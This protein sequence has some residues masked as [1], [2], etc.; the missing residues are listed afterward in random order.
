[1]ALTAQQK[2]FTLAGM[3]LAMFLAALDQTV[4]ATAGPV[5]QRDLSIAP[6]LYTWITTAYLVASTV[7]VPVYGKLSDTYGRR[8]I[9]VIGIVIFLAGSVACGLSKTTAQLIVFRALQGVGSASI[10]TSAFAVVADLFT[11][12]ERGKYSGVFGAVF[13]VSSLV[14]PLLGGLITDTVG[15]HWV[16]FINLPL[17]ALALAFIALR[18]PPLKPPEDR[19]GTVDVVGALLLGL[20]AVPLLIALSLGRPEVREGEVGFAWLSWPELALFATA[21]VGVAAFVAW[22]LRAKSPLIDLRLFRLPMVSWGSLTVF[23]LGGAFLTPMVFLPLFM[24]N[25]VGV[26][27][28]ASGLTIS[29]LVLGVVAGN[30][31]SGQL[32]ARLGR[33]KPIMLASLALLSAA[34]LLMV[35]TLST[36]STQGGVTAKMVLLGLGLGPTIPLYTIAIQNAVPLPQLGVAT[37]TVTFFRQMGGTVGLA[38]VGSLFGT[39]LAT[40]LAPRMAEA[41]KGLPPALVQRFAGG[42]GAVDAEGG[43]T[44]GHFDAAA[45]KAKVDEQLEGAQVL[46]HK[47]LKGDRLAA[48]LVAQSSLADERLKATAAAGGVRAEVAARFEALGRRL[49]DASQS[50]E[51]WE[52]LRADDSLP[53]AVKRQVREVPSSTMADERS[54]KSALAGL[55]LGVRLAQAADEQVALT[56]ATERVDRAVGAARTEAHAAVDAVAKALATA[57]T[58][59][60]RRVFEVALVLAVLALVLTFRVPQLSLRST[61]SPPVPAAA[62]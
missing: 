24:V 51:A 16:F 44:S 52:A 26:S 35:L 3:L 17:G 4:V 1:M 33:Y 45:V 50:P 54:R 25:V 31:L 2:L 12:R 19:R 40:E 9:V 22:E 42:P 62:E 28:T 60:I 59:A 14:G 21:A 58:E 23:V 6:S 48:T 37:S 5:I 7:L 46:A 55:A 38:V 49:E 27:A 34:F 29:P 39:T 20:G 13:G 36:S 43:R 8:R 61:S 32:V 41:T 57:F 15:W 18:M 30:V 47:A 10:F 56:E 53:D 11:P